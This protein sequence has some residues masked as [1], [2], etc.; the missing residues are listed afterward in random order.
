MRSSAKTIAGL[1]ATIGTLLT[2]GCWWF[3]LEPIQAPYITREPPYAAILQFPY[4]EDERILDFVV[5]QE[6]GARYDHTLSFSTRWQIRALQ[7]VPAAGFQVQIGHVPEGFKQLVP[8]NGDQFVPES[9]GKYML[10]ITT[11]NKRAHYCTWWA[12]TK[13]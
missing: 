8:A 5:H 4:K 6:L 11:T 2:G 12:P 10:T 13:Q 1:A 9:G 7:P 3:T